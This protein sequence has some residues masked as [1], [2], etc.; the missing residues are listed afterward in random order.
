MH[1]EKHITFED[2][3]PCVTYSLCLGQ[4]EAARV[5]GYI[6]AGIFDATEQNTIGTSDEIKCDKKSAS[7]M[8]AALAALG[9]Y[10]P[11]PTPVYCS[12]CLGRGD[13]PVGTTKRETCVACYGTGRKTVASVQEA[14]HVD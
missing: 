12:V 3:R 8:M 7:E 9:E 5:A 14:T 6:W 10:A 4:Y 2:D 13:F 11:A 1:I